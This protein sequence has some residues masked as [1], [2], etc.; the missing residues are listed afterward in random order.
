MRSYAWL[1]LPLS[2]L[3][4]PGSSVFAQSDDHSR[5]GRTWELGTSFQR[6]FFTE[7]DLPATGTELHVSRHLRGDW[8]LRGSLHRVVVIN[9]NAQGRLEGAQ[10]HWTDRRQTGGSIALSWDLIQFNTEALTHAVQFRGGPVLQI[11][12][13]ET[14]SSV[15]YAPEGRVEETLAAV[16][17]DPAYVVREDGSTY[18]LTTN[19]LDHTGLG[20]TL[21]MSYGVTYDRVTFR[22]RLSSQIGGAGRGAVHQAGVALGVRL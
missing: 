6:A 22:L 17:G 20:A 21:G 11:Q 4:F 15:T 5:S 8:G 1:L 16:E 19:S 14:V 12:R 3:F 9:R 7:G 2:L 10:R 13:G 18:V